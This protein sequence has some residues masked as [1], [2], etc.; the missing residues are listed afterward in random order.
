MSLSN[1]DQPAT[2]LEISPRVGEEREEIERMASWMESC[3]CV[4]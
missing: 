4:Q 1:I 3:D 2:K